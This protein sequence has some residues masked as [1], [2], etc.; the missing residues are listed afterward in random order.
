MGTESQ[1]FSWQDPN[2]AYV[3]IKGMTF[4]KLEKMFREQYPKEIEAASV[5]TLNRVANSIR[6]DATRELSNASSIKPSKILRARMKITRANKNRIVAA[7]SFR[8]API[9][10]EMLAGKSGPTW[11]RKSKGVRTKGRFYD[12]AF[13]ATP[14]AGRFAGKRQ[15]IY[16]RVSRTNTNKVDL[17]AQY[18]KLDQLAPLF[19]TVARSTINAKAEKEFTRQLNFRLSKIG[20]V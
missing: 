2:M 13:L 16:N 1:R 20:K 17:H 19:I 11:S 14:K 10:A 12:N 15:R 3:N 4:G 5:S 9:P 18:V 6:S 8:Y 7:V